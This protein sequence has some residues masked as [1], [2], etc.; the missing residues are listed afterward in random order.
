MTTQQPLAYTLERA[1]EVCG[2]VVTLN[3]LTEAVRRREIEHV[4]VGRNIGIT[5]AQLRAF[6]DAH[7]VTPARSDADAPSLP[8]VEIP[9]LTARSRTHHARKAAR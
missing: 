2:G 5:P 6:I 3:Y 4:R 8:P 1:V 9:S 7:T